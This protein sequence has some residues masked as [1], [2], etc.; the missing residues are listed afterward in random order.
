MGTETEYAVSQRGVD[1]YNP[2][3]LSFD[4][5]AAAADPRTRISDGT[6]GARIRSTTRA[7]TA[8]RVPPR[9]RIC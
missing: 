6:T 5:V 9:T 3:R 4:V 7:A 1:R 2:V 8:C